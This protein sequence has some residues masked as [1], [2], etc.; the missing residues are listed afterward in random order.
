MRS[1]PRP[2]AASPP[3]P[4]TRP[5]RVIKGRKKK[6]IANINRD[7]VS[8]PPVE[9]VQ[10]VYTSYKHT[11]PDLSGLFNITIHANGV[12][13]SNYM[14]RLGLGKE[15]FMSD[16]KERLTRLRYM[17]KHEEQFKIDSKWIQRHN[18][19][20]SHRFAVVSWMHDVFLFKVNVMVVCYE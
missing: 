3:K 16:L 6:S 9:T 5:E 4:A 20:P 1:P 7:N 8:A 17:V 19:L 15:K 18:L 2:I 11:T 10:P 12:H 14:E 13:K